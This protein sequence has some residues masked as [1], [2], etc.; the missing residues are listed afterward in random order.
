MFSF[1]KKKKSNK[2]TIMLGIV[3]VLFVLLFYSLWTLRYVVWQLDDLG[4][5]VV[6]MAEDFN[7]TSPELKSEK[8]MVAMAIIEDIQG[9]LDRL[10]FVRLAPVLRGMYY[11]IQDSFDQVGQIFF[12]LNKLNTELADVYGDKLSE[13]TLASYF[14]QVDEEELNNKIKSISS[15]LTNMEDNLT[16]LSKDVDSLSNT[17]LLKSQKETM[18][19]MS[20][21]VNEFASILSKVNELIDI[22]PELLGYPDEMNYLLLLQNNH[23]MRATGGFIGNYGILTVH[24]GRVKNIFI[25]DI[26]HLDS[27]IIGELEIEPPSPIREYLNVKYWYMR[28]SNW[29]PDFPTAARKAI[30]F[31]NL[32]G[33]SETID[34]VMAISPDVISDLLD[35]TGDIL[36]SDVLYE[37]DNFTNILQYEVEQNYEARGVSHWDRKDIISDI[38]NT[39]IENLSSLPLEKIFKIVDVIYD[40]LDSKDIQIYSLA[41]DTQ[42]YL[43]EKNWSGRLISTDKDYLMVVDSNM[44]AYK[45]NQYVDRSIDYYV[46]K[47][48]NPVG[49]DYAIATVKIK[50]D[51]SG[52]FS[53]DTTRYR[54]YTRIYVPK[55]SILISWDGAMADDRTT[56]PG[57]I[58]ISQEQDKTVYG[59]F[60][61]IEP[62]ETGELTM[63]YRLPDSVL[64]NYTFTYQRQ[65]GMED[66]LSTSLFNR[67]SSHMPVES[68][69]EIRL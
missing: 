37:S 32:E 1:R 67:K 14:L 13:K 30:E 11:D 22:A 29:S 21:G 36:I 49:E 5:V 66:N 33:G 54:T 9:Q 57:N 41:N 10:R 31:Y 34:G 28:D 24:N 63:Q 44:A 25:D 48:K 3:V 23:E 38:A 45:T 20:S 50:Y 39:M 17:W 56:E 18:L 2:L 64:K 60:I 47:V 19:K 42:K 40:N 68:D 46:Q 62:G 65:S 58:D 12:Y 59:T 15:I 69:I 43:N 7:E 61:A 4:D 35:V 51:H 53:W 52:D 8:L 26:Y 6:S 55:G 16:V 27:E